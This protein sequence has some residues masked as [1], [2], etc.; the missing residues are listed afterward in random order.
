MFWNSEITLKTQDCLF[1]EISE[2]EEETILNKNCLF[3]KISEK[4]EET[5]L[6]KQAV[7][8]GYFFAPK[9]LN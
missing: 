9:K 6:K 1:C 3:C 2:K 5:I 4:E 8:T 7:I